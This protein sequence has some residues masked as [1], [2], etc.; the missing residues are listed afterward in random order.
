MEGKRDGGE[1]LNFKEEC[2]VS[3]GGGRETLEVSEKQRERVDDD[4]HA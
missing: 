4:G 1:G 3:L 2:N